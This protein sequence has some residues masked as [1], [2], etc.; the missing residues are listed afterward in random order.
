M[1]WRHRKRCVWRHVRTF[2]PRKKAGEW[3]KFSTLSDS[4]PPGGLLDNSNTLTP[5]CKKFNFRQRKNIEKGHRKS[6]ASRHR[7]HHTQGTFPGTHAPY[8]LRDAKSQHSAR[9]NR[10]PYQ[11]HTAQHIPSVKRSTTHKHHRKRQ[12]ALTV[13]GAVSALCPWHVPTHFGNVPRAPSGLGSGF[14]LSR[15]GDATQTKNRPA[16]TVPQQHFTRHI[17]QPSCCVPPMQSQHIPV[18]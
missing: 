11:K 7:Q 16:P 10:N 12:C 18:C 15:L 3:N 17:F 9:T 14:M 6:V 5:P 8:A 4:Q 1:R 13:G 2:E